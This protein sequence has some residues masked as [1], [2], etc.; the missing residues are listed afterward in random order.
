MNNQKQFKV[1]DKVKVSFNE[2]ILDEYKSLCGIFYSIYITS[3]ENLIKALSNLE[4]EGMVVKVE[5]AGDFIH[6]KFD[7]DIAKQYRLL[8]SF[9]LEKNTDDTGFIVAIPVCFLEHVEEHDKSINKSE[10]VPYYNNQNDEEKLPVAEIRLYD[11]MAT[12]F[13][14]QEKNYISLNISR[15]KEEPLKNLFHRAIKVAEDQ[16]VEPKDDELVVEHP[17]S[18]RIKQGDKYV[19]LTGIGTETEF[20]VYK[21]QHFMCIIDKKI[22]NMFD[23]DL[24]ALACQE[25]VL[26]KLRN[27]MDE[28]ENKN[29]E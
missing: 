22:G 5:D 8:L 9:Y 18:D 12:V 16:F 19:R 23:N 26:D 14:P 13:I 6:V 3:Y 10:V 27:V 25:E 2:N 11:D 17:L 28:E 21:P 29:V 20:C 1:G 4:L 7:K 15:W 24:E